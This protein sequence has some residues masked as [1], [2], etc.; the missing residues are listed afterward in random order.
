[1]SDPSSP[2]PRAI[3]GQTRIA[4][5]RFVAGR[6]HQLDA[7]R[8]SASTR[9]T[10][11][12][13]RRAVAREVGSVPEI[14]QVT[15]DGAPGT[16]RGDAPTVEEI[17]IHATLTLYAVHQQS[18]VESMHRRGAGLGHAVRRLEARAGQPG[19]S[20]VSPVR[21]RFDA[22]ATSQSV[23]EARHHLRGLV[24]QL[25]ANGIPLDYGMLAEDL[26]DLQIAHRA[27]SVRLRWAR[28]YYRIDDGDDGK[29]SAVPEQG[30]SDD[31]TQEED[32]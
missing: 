9:A 1:M 25:S 28:Q 2:A 20:D 26:H 24:G 18:K 14:W 6:V 11:A 23:S 3:P 22:L 16:P 15:L 7:S 8:E 13:L 21:R 27:P 5:G 32:Q 19:S 12:N 17:A 29:V 4:V 30:R 10:L 31:A